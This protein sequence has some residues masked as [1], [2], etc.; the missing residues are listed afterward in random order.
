MKQVAIF[1][2]AARTATLGALLAGLFV[3][4]PGQAAEGGWK[5]V[6]PIEIVVSQ[7]AGGTTDVMAR[8]IQRI[9]QN[10][11]LTQAPINVTNKPGGGGGV[12]LNY[13]SKRPAD[14]HSISVGNATMISTHIVGRSK[15]TYTDFAPIATLNQDVVAFAVHPSSPLKS[16]KDLVDRLK[17]DPASISIAIG[18]AVGN[19]NHIAI[20][21]VAKSVGVDARKLKTVIFKSGAETMT[22]ILGGHVDIGMT[23]SGQF[24]KHVEAGRVRL[25]ALAAPQ[26][27]EG[28]LAGIPTWR[29]QGVDS[30]AG[31]WYA[32]FGPKDTPATAIR[33]WEEA[34]AAVERHEEWR[35][36][37]RNRQMLSLYRGSEETGKFFKSEYERLKGILAELGLAK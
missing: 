18:A 13:L 20:A 5:P 27:L 19:Q 25:I 37:V 16:G 12:G 30:V 8:L 35:R 23:S 26:R 1:E 24:V 2:A 6:D 36:L 14:G 28:P 11:G 22:Q 15:L 3:G 17:Q 9:M 7:G 21:L 10:E 4:A 34:V 33:Y 29:E 32:V 31:L